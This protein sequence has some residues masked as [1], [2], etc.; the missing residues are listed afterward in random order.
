MDMKT[1][2]VNSDVPARPRH[3]VTQAKP[4]V[5]IG[6][7]GAGKSTVGRK[8]AKAMDL[9]FVDSDLAIEEAAGCSISDMFEIHGESMFRDL[10]RRVITRLLTG[11]MLVLATGGGAWMQ[12]AVREVIR[13]HAVTVWL[14]ADVDVL[15]E[16]VSKRS[17]RPIL[18]KGDKRAILTS[19]M[20][21]RYPVY[22]EADITIDS[23]RGSQEA[24][25]KRIMS[26]LK[27]FQRR[28]V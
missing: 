15:L 16:R 24:L 14:K 5:L 22:A 18:E 21:E 6:L 7:M 8:L 20:E 19:L 27:T 11:D 26:S 9:P 12:P 1:Q 10:E 2:Q 17:H 4:V 25:V 28:A 13:A 3:A 23:N